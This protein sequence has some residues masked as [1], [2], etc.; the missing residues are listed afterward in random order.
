M[1]RIELDICKENIFIDEIRPWKPNKRS[2]MV[3]RS[4]I[5]IHTV[6]SWITKHPGNVVVSLMLMRLSLLLWTTEGLGNKSRRSQWPDNIVRWRLHHRLV[7]LNLILLGKRHP[8]QYQCLRTVFLWNK[9]DLERW[10]QSEPITCDIKECTQKPHEVLNDWLPHQDEFLWEML[11]LEA[12]NDNMTCPC[13]PALAF[14]FCCL[15][16]LGSPLLCLRCCL[17]NHRSNPYHKIEV[18][19]GRCFLSSDLH[20]I[21]IKLYLGHG[22]DPCPTILGQKSAKIP[23]K[24]QDHNN[25]SSEDDD[26]S[27]W[28]DEEI[29]EDVITVV[30]ATGVYKRCVRWC[31]CTTAPPR[32]IQFMR[33]W[34]YPSTVKRPQ[35]AFT[36]SLLDHFYI[37]SME[38]KTSA[39]N[40]FNKLRRLTSNAF[41]HSIPVRLLTKPIINHYV[42]Y[43]AE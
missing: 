32:H 39:N 41:P 11:N 30:H 25:I 4:I 6:S 18:W 33:M 2:V 43:W 15:E 19:N 31:T 36:F 5:K 20:E 13:C 16:C 17:E 38:C 35:T 26:V 7:G 29:L 14:Q 27:V 40:F 22:G 21:G 24:T 34:L 23:A 1:D 9:I 3:G 12:P 42:S 10:I 8:T 37:D 28:D